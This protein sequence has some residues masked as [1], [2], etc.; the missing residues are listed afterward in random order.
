MNDKLPP[1]ELIEVLI[2]P[3]FVHS[4]YT[5]SRNF[6]AKCFGFAVIGANILLF[7]FYFLMRSLLHL[8]FC[9][10]LLNNCSMQLLLLR[11]WCWF[12][13][14]SGLFAYF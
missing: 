7:I 8:L 3:D 9:R 12:S 11:G 10:L 6:S 4:L 1:E 13:H 14:L 2:I 5:F